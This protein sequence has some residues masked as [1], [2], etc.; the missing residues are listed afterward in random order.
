MTAAQKN[1]LTSNQSESG[2]VINQERHQERRAVHPLQT[3]WT[4]TFE[5]FLDMMNPVAEHV[6]ASQRVQDMKNAYLQS[7]NGLEA[8]MYAPF[9]VLVNTI[10]DEIKSEVGSP[11]YLVHS[12]HHPMVGPLPK[13]FTKPDLV[14][15]RAHLSTAF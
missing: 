13:F 2:T 3:I 1:K 5:D 9:C 7:C 8:S 15:S 12:E 6:A 11:L 4:D 10:G 14:W